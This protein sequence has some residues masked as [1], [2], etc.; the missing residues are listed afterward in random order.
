MISYFYYTEDPTF[1]IEENNEAETSGMKK[2][3]IWVYDL[4]CEFFLSY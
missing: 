1:N 4:I 2:L 3:N